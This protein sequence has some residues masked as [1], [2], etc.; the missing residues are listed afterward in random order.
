MNNTY[1]NLD[2]KDHHRQFSSWLETIIELGT[3]KDQFRDKARHNPNYLRR[4]KRIYE[5]LLKGYTLSDYDA[6]SLLTDLRYAQIRPPAEY[7]GDQIEL[8]CLELNAFLATEE[9]RQWR[10]G[11]RVSF[12]RH[13]QHAIKTKKKRRGDDQ[14]TSTRDSG[15]PEVD[16]RWDSGGAQVVD[17]PR[18]SQTESAIDIEV[19]LEKELEGDGSPGGED[20]FASQPASPSTEEQKQMKMAD[21]INSELPSDWFPPKGAKEVIVDVWKND[22]N[23]CGFNLYFQF[24]AKYSCYVDPIAADKF[25]GKGHFGENYKQLLLDIADIADE[26]NRSYPTYVGY[27]KPNGKKKGLPNHFV[28]TQ[29]MEN[30]W[31]IQ[32]L[33]LR[34]N[35]LEEFNV[36]IGRGKGKKRLGR[37][38]VHL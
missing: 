36:A 4:L 7:G 21:V 8:N 24:G 11:L 32:F 28:I 15:R 6:K 34:A 10:K 3:R 30:G 26:L 9:G 16:V 13:I 22:R 37:K 33:L 27:L 38:Q 14:D 29:E 2:F 19:E 23:P 25:G 31:H 17:N 12:N 18:E 35:G 5:H 20:S 1:H